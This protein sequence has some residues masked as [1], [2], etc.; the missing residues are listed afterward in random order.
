MR[1]QVLLVALLTASACAGPSPVAPSEGTWKFSGNISALDGT[2]PAGPIAG[3][4]LTVVSG[5]NMNAKVT[6]DNAGNY[7][8]PSLDSGRFTV[9]IAKPGYVSATPV[10]DLYRDTEVNFA[11][12]PR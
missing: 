4:E 2:R 3:A 11:L 7:V 12:Q 10:V 9:T 6:T 8:F 5:V 1:L